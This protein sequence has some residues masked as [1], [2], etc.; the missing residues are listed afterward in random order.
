[1]AEAGLPVEG[2]HGLACGVVYKLKGTGIVFK[3]ESSAVQVSCCS[4]SISESSNVVG[5]AVQ[6]DGGL[7]ID[8]TKD[9]ALRHQAGEV[10][11]AQGRGEGE[12][13]R[14]ETIADGEVVTFFLHRHL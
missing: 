4:A 6:S 2:C 14:D 9:G 5:Q 7:W 13:P 1:M 10:D 12:L 3:L 11:G 8:G